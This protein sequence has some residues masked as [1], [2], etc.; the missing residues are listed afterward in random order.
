MHYLRKS[1]EAS[2]VSAHYDNSHY[3]QSK[4]TADYP[5]FASQR[6]SSYVLSQ[7]SVYSTRQFYF[8]IN[9]EVSK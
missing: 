1:K 3:L 5:L 6:S 7:E 9:M 4:L 2:V 8:S